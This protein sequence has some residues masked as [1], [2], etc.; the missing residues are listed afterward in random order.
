MHTHTF[1]NCKARRKKFQ[2]LLGLEGKVER[3]RKSMK[4]G[5]DRLVGKD[6]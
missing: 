2:K 6:E 5:F 1:V 4:E 3:G